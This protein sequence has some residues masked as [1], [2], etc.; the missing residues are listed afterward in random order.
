MRR[1]TIV[2]FVTLA[3]GAPGIA[4]NKLENPAAIENL[5]TQVERGGYECA[6]VVSA[7]RVEDDAYGRTEFMV[8]CAVAPAGALYRVT[9][10][11][12]GRALVAPWR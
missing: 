6:R 1:I 7:Y 12:R 5:M 11:P 2:I 3:L 4:A 10:P 9:V 8:A